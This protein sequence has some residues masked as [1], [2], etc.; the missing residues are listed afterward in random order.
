[1]INLTHH[2]NAFETIFRG[3]SVVVERGIVE[4]KKGNDSISILPN[5]KDELNVFF[6]E[7]SSK[8]EKLSHLDMRKISLEIAEA[9]SPF[10]ITLV[11]YDNRS[12]SDCCTIYDSKTT[13]VK[14][15]RYKDTFKR[16]LSI[17]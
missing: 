7:F 10:G 13:S 8:K 2:E 9:L 4:A 12:K 14:R 17:F 15:Q 16:V 1:M 5:G 11:V 6:D 3:F